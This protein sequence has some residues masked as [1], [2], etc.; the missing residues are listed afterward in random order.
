MV[1][2]MTDPFDATMSLLRKAAT[3]AARQATEEA[4]AAEI[5][6]AGLVRDRRKSLMKVQRERLMRPYPK[7]RFGLFAARR[8]DRRVRRKLSSGLGR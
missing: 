8:L 2:M 6:V 5:V 1:M 3:L 4:D 7:R